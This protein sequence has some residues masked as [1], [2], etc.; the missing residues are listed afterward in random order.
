[1]P[2]PRQLQLT[3]NKCHRKPDQAGKS[4]CA[5]TQ[6]QPL[7]PASSAAWTA[8]SPALPPSTSSAV[9]SGTRRRKVRTCA[10]LSNRWR[11]QWLTTAS[12]WAI[13]QT[14]FGSY[15]PNYLPLNSLQGA[16]SPYTEP[17]VEALGYHQ[18][19]RREVRKSGLF[20]SEMLVSVGLPENLSLPGASHSSARP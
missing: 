5:R 6:R 14:L 16:Y 12:P 13:V 7:P 3:G 11:A 1:M 4:S 17:S 18:S 2:L 19:L 10:V 15:S 8:R 9:C 20:C